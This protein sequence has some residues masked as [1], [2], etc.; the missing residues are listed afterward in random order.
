MS[1]TAVF[2]DVTVLA[3]SGAAPAVAPGV[4]RRPV[5]PPI[6]RSRKEFGG[7][8]AAPAA[9]VA[10]IYLN[11]VLFGAYDE[12]ALLRGATAF[13]LTVIGV[14][15]AVDRGA[16]ARSAPVRKRADSPP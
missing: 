12:A 10:L 13:L 16:R 11:Q 7:P 4:L 3:S 5:T 15:A 1:R 2:L 6:A 14:C 9:V 8:A